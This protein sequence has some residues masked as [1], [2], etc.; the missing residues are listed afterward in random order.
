MILSVN[1]EPV[2]SNP[3]P[4]RRRFTRPRGLLVRYLPLVAILCLLC[5]ALAVAGPRLNELV[6]ALIALGSAVMG[7]EDSDALAEFFTPEVD[8][9]KSSIVRWAAVF[10]LDPNLVATIMQIESCGDPGAVSVAGAQGLMQVMP[11]HFSGTED[12]MDPDTNIR[13]G[14][15]V[16]TECLYS[17][18]NPGREI[19]LAFACYNGG[20]SVF[21]TDWNVWPQ[22]SRDYYI[23]GTAIYG[24]ALVENPESEALQRWLAAGGARLCEAARRNLNLGEDGS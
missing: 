16:F 11:M 13:R 14:L 19:G 24:D 21:V 23:W 2:T 3:A 22:Q 15:E 12:P 20:P 8:Y 18:Y 7:E 4:S 9:W 17:Q 6:T 5:G 1:D 10:D